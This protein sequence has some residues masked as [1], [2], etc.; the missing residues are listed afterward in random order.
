MIRIAEEKDLLSVAAIEKDLFSLPWSHENF[1]EALCNPAAMIWV[2]ESEAGQIN[3]YLVMYCSI[4]EGEITN[5]ATRSDC[6]NQGI[7]SSLVDTAIAYAN[8]NDL[9]RIVLEVR[10]S[11]Q[12]AISVYEKKGF[13]NLGIRKD[14]YEKPREDAMIMA[15]EK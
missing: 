12:N 9:P 6:R 1:L 7:G 2:S 10:V 5:V 14:F 3:G 4:D 13:V 8:Q 11:N 15:W